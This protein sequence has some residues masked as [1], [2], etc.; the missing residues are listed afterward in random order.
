MPTFA[1]MQCTRNLTRM[2][3]L[4]QNVDRLGYVE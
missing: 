2:H 4:L 3:M 1:N